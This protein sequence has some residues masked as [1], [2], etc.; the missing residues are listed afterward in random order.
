ML[1]IGLTGA[2]AS[3][4]STVGQILQEFGAAVFDADRI[5]AD[6]YAQG[7]AGTR[8]IERLFGAEM[9]DA[10]GRVSKQ[11]LAR[12]AFDDPAARR[13]IEAAIHPLVAAEIRRRFAEAERSGA[14]V[15]VVEA[16]QI[17]EAGYRTEFDRIL[18]V[19]APEEARLVR[20]EARGVPADEIRRRSAAQLRA[21]DARAS[22]DDVVENAGS[23]AA[24]REEVGALFARWRKLRPHA[25][26]RR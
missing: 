21:D 4:K 25:P 1:R 12:L 5:V 17:L 19:A 10:D 13:R 11:A 14:P 6:L 8:A 16:S 18:L 22:A 2:I 3:G 23:P 15:A 7:A 20:G 26:A 9:L 24:L